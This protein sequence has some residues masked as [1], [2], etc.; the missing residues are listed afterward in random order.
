MNI[1]KKLPRGGGYIS[2][3]CAAGPCDLSAMVL[4]FFIV[5]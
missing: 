4:F 3:P 2:N 5:T 1:V